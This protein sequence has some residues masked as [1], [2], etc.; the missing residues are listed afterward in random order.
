MTPPGLRL[1]PVREQCGW[2]FKSLTPGP[3]KA[4]RLDA[5]GK[6]LTFQRLGGGGRSEMLGGA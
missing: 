5:C 2:N 4:L 3:Y 1:D 6:D